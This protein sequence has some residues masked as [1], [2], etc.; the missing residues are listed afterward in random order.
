[1]E[2]SPAFD[3]FSNGFENSISSRSNG[4]PNFCENCVLRLRRIIPPLKSYDKCN[5]RQQ[6]QQCRRSGAFQL[7]ESEEPQYGYNFPNLRNRA[8]HGCRLCSL[9]LRA[10]TKEEV[11]LTGWLRESPPSHGYSRLN[12]TCYNDPQR[13]NR[14][15]Q[16]ELNVDWSLE[17]DF[18]IDDEVR[19]KR[20]TVK[21]VEVKRRW[22][23]VATNKS[24][25]YRTEPSRTTSSAASVDQIEKW[26]KHCNFFHSCY[27]GRQTNSFLPTRLVELVDGVDKLRLCDS[28]QLP[29]ETRYATISYCWGDARFCRLL[30]QN[31]SSFR[32]NIPFSILPQTFQDA[33]TLL[34][35]LYIK[36]LWIDALCIVQ[37]SAADWT[38]EAAKMSKV[39]TNSYL[40]LAATASQN[41]QEGLFRARE[42][43]Y[44]K[45]CRYVPRAEENGWGW[46]GH[47]QGEPTD[48]WDCVNPSD[49]V[50]AIV[51]TPLHSRAWVYQERALAPRILHFACAELFWECNHKRASETFPDGLPKEYVLPKHKSLLD[52]Y[53]LQMKVIP[54]SPREALVD[55]TSL[56]RFLGTF[57][58][59]DENSPLD[60]WT[61][62]VEDYSSTR[63]TYATDKLVAI[64]ALAETFAHNFKDKYLGLFAGQPVEH[65]PTNLTYLAGL[66]SDQL[67][68]QLLWN[69]KS[70]V[71]T[72]VLGPSPYIAP[73][74]SW[75]SVTS[76]IDYSHVRRPRRY[77]SPLSKLLFANAIPSSAPY[78]AVTAGSIKVLGPLFRARFEPPTRYPTRYEH[79][80]TRLHFSSS[81]DGRLYASL[82]DAR[83]KA[84]GKVFC[85]PLFLSPGKMRSHVEIEGLLLV[86]TL[87]GRYRRAGTFSHLPMHYEA[88]F[89]EI[90]ESQEPNCLERGG[91][92]TAT[93]D[94]LFG[95]VGE[96]VE[97]DGYKRMEVGVFEV[98][99]V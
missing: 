94:E 6:S 5:N 26:I 8:T 90:K 88:L 14:S 48:G 76:P 85:L 15:R 66:W 38:A 32:D 46:T 42:P 19:T 24:S 29:R 25:L 96:F 27:Q 37:D 13:L 78:G 17:K 31:M 55:A 75:A 70:H 79:Y 20:V 92:R 97:G 84:Q 81:R 82:D 60:W 86:P 80:S 98:E 99:I 43:S 11:S 77:L 35:R 2:D 22:M 30:K 49:W 59:E 52:A 67:L 58:Y 36:Y 9:I 39:Y 68:E 74:W 91:E 65:F 54:P 56:G 87:A 10:F 69:V 3:S 64:S 40:N 89:K 41:P 57:I 61:Q 44:V 71:F 12:E 7:A 53:L 73:S 45:P 34:D 51:E 93:L 1:M 62:I 47:I 23:P 21:V 72:T 83:N 16:F 4:D 63:L 18:S 50:T 28:D 33:M 95:D